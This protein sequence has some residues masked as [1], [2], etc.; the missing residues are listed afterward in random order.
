MKSSLKKQNFVFTFFY[1]KDTKYHGHVNEKHRQKNK[2]E[3][4]NLVFHSTVLRASSVYLLIIITHCSSLFFKQ[5]VG[6]S[7]C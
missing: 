2:S 3:W 1:F 4:G 6:R 7:D 5:L